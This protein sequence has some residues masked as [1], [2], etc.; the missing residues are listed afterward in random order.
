MSSAKTNM[1]KSDISLKRSIAA[2]LLPSSAFFDRTNWTSKWSCTIKRADCPRFRN[3]EKIYDHLQPTFLQG[4]P[5]DYIEFGVAD[6]SSLRSWCAINQHFGSR[7]FGLDSFAGFPEDWAAD[8]PKGTFNWGGVPPDIADPQVRFYIG[9]YQDSVPGF[10]DSYRPLNRVGIH[11]NSDLYSSTLYTLTVMERVASPDT[12]VIFDNFW[13]AL[14]E[15]RALS[16]FSAAYRRASKVIA[17]TR[18]FCQVALTF[19][20]KEF[21][22]PK[23][24]T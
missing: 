1:A 7:F 6:G 13:E 15:Y 8:H 9:L 10:L 17:A 19:S 12:I 2:L 24:E 18:G 23:G 11:N 4:S 20:S 16:D 14:H 3:R 22:G 21:Y 5:I